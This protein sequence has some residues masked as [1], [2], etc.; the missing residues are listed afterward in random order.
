M[1]LAITIEQ[2][3]TANSGKFLQNAWYVAALSDSIG[4]EL[5]PLKLLSESVVVYRSKDGQ[6][7][8]L[9]DA[10]PHRKL[11]LSMGRLVDDHMS[12]VATMDFV[13]IRIWKMPYCANPRTYSANCCRQNLPGTRQVWL[14]LGL[15]G[16]SKSR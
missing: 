4:R 15:D 5:T 13:S 8:V 1:L 11:P 9:E 3:I 12:S 14:A 2:S 10:C 6:A 7:V 16:R